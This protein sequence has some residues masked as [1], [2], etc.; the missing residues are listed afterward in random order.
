MKKSDRLRS[1]FG[2]VFDEQ[3]VTPSTDLILPSTYSDD[4]DIVGLMNSAKDPDTG[5]LRDVKIDDGDLHHASSYYDF[6]FNVIK[7][8]ANPPWMIQMWIGVMLFAEYCPCCSDKRWTSLEWVVDHVSKGEPSQGITEHLQMLKHGKCPKCGRYKYELIKDHGLNDYIEL[9]SV[10]GQ[11]SGKS[12]SAA[13]YASYLTHRYLKFPKLATM[14]RAMQKSTELTGT[15]VSLTF[16]KAYSLLWTPYINIINEST[17]FCLAEGSL[18][19]LE[20]GQKLAIEDVTPGTRVKTLDGSNEVTHLFVNGVKECHDVLLNNGGVLTGTN[21][22]MVRCLSPDGESL[23]WKSIGEL[24]EG[25]LVLTESYYGHQEETL[26][27]QKMVEGKIRTF[28]KVVGK[29]AVGPRKVYDLE[30]ANVH[31]YYANGVNVH[32]CEYHKVLDLATEKYGVEIYRKKDEFIKYFH[33]GLR[34]YPTNPKSQTLRG[35]TRVMGIIDELGLFPLPSGNDEE[36]ETSD[37]ANADEAHKSLSNSLVTVQSVHQELLAKRHNCPPAILMGVSSPISMKDK[38]MRLL[39]ESR[40]TES[41][42]YIL[43]V[44]LPTWKVNPYLERSSP[45]IANAYAANPVKAERDFG[46]NPP[47]VSQTYLKPQQVPRSL[48]KGKNSHTLEYQYDK[49]GLLYAKVKQVY[50]PKF[51]SVV[52]IDAGYS[53]NSFSLVAGHFDFDRQKTVISTLLEIMTHDGRKIDF[54]SVYLNMILPVLQHTNSVLLLADQWQSLDLLSRAR[55]DMGKNRHGKNN[56]ITK[57]Y[58]PKRRDFDSLVSMLENGSI[59]L[60]FLSDADYDDVCERYIDYKT[61]LKEPAKHLM[62]QMLTVRDT[63]PNQAPTKGEGFT[64][65][66]FRACT[67][68]VKIHDERVMERLDQARK[69]MKDDGRL[70]MPKPVYVSYGGFS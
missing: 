39:A 26:Q 25:D 27:M 35:D 46:A 15:F 70:G 29:R 20:S 57:Q 41:K 49:P 4:F 14:T 23:I 19:T 56:C 31:N 59:E 3:I 40:K 10:L 36:D 67:L 69:E 13:S 34:F 58:S 48:W 61:L 17:W 42:R 22:H 2:D 33:K 53:N 38:V 68:L 63:G 12:A 9:V 30:V 28:A 1:L 47:R 21:E 44:N 51:P 66:L 32:N 6:C 50:K 62:L 54:N 5:L 65:D 60:P 16:N 43:G 7:E 24:T 37:R 52:G 11:R 64:D 18:V 45:N 8:D 55:D